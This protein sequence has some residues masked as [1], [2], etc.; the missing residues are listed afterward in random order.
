M[1]APSPRRHPFPLALAVA[2]A[3]AGLAAREIGAEVGA[4][5]HRVYH[6]LK[7]FGGLRGAR[8]RGVR[9]AVIALARA[10]VGAREIAARTGCSTWSVHRIARECGVEVVRRRERRPR[11]EAEAVIALARAGVG[12]RE[13]AARTGCSLWSVY[14][15]ARECGVEVAAPPSR[16]NVA[17]NQAIMA[18][19][20]SG[21]TLREIGAAHGLT[22][23]RVQII[24][25]R[26]G[27]DPLGGWRRPPPNKVPESERERCV[28]L[29][30]R[31][32][33]TPEIAVALGRSLGTIRALLRDAGVTQRERYAAW[34]YKAH[35]DAVRRLY[36]AGRSYNEIARAIGKRH[37]SA[38]QQIVVR[39]GLP[40]R[41]RGFKRHAEVYGRDA[42]GP[43]A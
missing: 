20:R 41:G 23:Q 36:L 11:P 21:S 39:L 4:T 5:E 6:A 24:I 34:G 8:R 15:I 3:E 28:A 9:S 22:Y 13:I 10:G 12:A 32:L 29:L 35:D 37:A 31:G 38:V 42:V 27:G 17:R 19:R 33:R 30:R 18:M 25:K 43:P 16:S 40:R 7:P 2:L 1:T 14:R 26:A